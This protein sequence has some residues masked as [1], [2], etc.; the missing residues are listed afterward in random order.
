L[1][2][3]VR[4]RNKADIEKA[5]EEILAVVGLETMAS[6]APAHLSGGQ[7]QRVALA[8][9]LICEPRLI[10]LD[11][12][13][14]ALDVDLRRQIQDF[15]RA[16]QRRSGITFLFVTH[17]QQEAISFSDQ[18]LVMNKGSVDQVATP[19]ELYCRP[20]TPFVAGFFGYNKVIK[21][22]VSF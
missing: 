8:R 21:R 1:K 12:P 19:Q 3:G 16:Q 18:V 7:R 17:Y 13:L 20:P 2:R 5:V 15:L 4:G 6:R 11:E 14:A 22:T 9:A 10:L